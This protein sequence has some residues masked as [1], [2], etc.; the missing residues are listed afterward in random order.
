MRRREF[1]ITAGASLAPL[2]AGRAAD[3]RPFMSLSYTPS[4]IDLE[5]ELAR[6]IAETRIRLDLEHIKKFTGHIRTYTLDRGLDRVLPMA[7]AAGLKVSVGLWLSRD[8]TKNDLEFGRALKIFRSHGRIIDRIYVGN[9]TLVRKDLSAPDLIGYLRRVRV[10]IPDPAVK[11]GTGEAW[12]EWQT[13]P[14]VVAA[15]DFIGAHLY[16]YWDGVPMAEGVDYVARKYTELKNVYPNKTVVIAETGWPSAGPTKG[17][18]VPSPEAQEQ[19][20]RMFLTRAAREKY[21]YSFFE[22]YDQPWKAMDIEGAVGGHWG[23]FGRRREPK[24]PFVKT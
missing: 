18:A 6:G 5:A 11:I 4:G 23:L 1:M 9:E 21:D 13:N 8:K 16:P 15:C 2:A 24:I 17:G 19:F 12:H 22:A 10:S 7:E 3:R 14:D 20:V